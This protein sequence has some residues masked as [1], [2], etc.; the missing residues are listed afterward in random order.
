MRENSDEDPVAFQIIF[1]NI[2]DILLQQTTHVE[3]SKYWVE[4]DRI[5]QMEELEFKHFVK[6]SEK[7]PFFVRSLND[8]CIFFRGKLYIFGN[9]AE[10]YYCALV[11]WILLLNVECHGMLNTSDS[12][13]PF[14][15]FVCSLKTNP[16]LQTAAQ[17]KAASSSAFFSR[18]EE[19]LRRAYDLFKRVKKDLSGNQ[20]SANSS[21]TIGVVE[22]TG[23]RPSGHSGWDLDWDSD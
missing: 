2:M 21:N 6:D 12:I 19:E 20:R 3:F 23:L 18:A 22:S 17:A 16:P 1:K 7:T 11:H 8:A 5:Y 13:Q 9:K 10:H 14:V 15:D 4:G